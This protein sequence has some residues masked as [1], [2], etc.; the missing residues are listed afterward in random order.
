MIASKPAWPRGPL[1]SK[2]HVK[3][4]RNFFHSFFIGNAQKNALFYIDL[5]ISCFGY[6]IARI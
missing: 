4:V 6:D 1:K 3:R 5:T 2:I